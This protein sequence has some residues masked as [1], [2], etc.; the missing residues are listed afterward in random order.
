MAPQDKFPGRASS[1][2]PTSRGGSDPPPQKTP[3]IVPLDADALAGLCARIIA[4]LETLRATIDGYIGRRHD[5]NERVLNVLKE[6]VENSTAILREVKGY[7]KRIEEIEVHLVEV[8]E[9]LHD[10][11]K[12]G[13]E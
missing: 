7:D 13:K 6:L 3:S 10:L 9:Q 1:E 4:K 5:D 8:E 11:L 2:A 12:N